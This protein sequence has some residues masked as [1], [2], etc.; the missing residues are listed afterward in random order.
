MARGQALEVLSDARD[1]G[2]MTTN[3]E[4]RMKEVEQLLIQ[5]RTL[6]HSFSADSV[7]GKAIAGIT[8]ADSVRVASAELIDEYYFRRKGLGLATLFITLL[9]VLLYYRIR[10]LEK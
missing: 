5:T 10:R 2:M 6:I 1:K 9:G 7:A 4:F 3:E 8:V